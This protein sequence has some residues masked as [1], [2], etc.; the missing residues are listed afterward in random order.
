MVCP[1]TDL[2]L[3]SGKHSQQSLETI[4]ILTLEF[5]HASM[6]GMDTN[7]CIAIKCR[8]EACF[9]RELITCTH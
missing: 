3:P 1:L 4:V 8:I 5:D 2:R 9:H 6:V 7:R